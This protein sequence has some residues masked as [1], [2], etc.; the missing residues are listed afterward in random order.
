MTSSPLPAVGNTDLPF[1]I[2]G[3]GAFQIQQQRRKLIANLK[4]QMR[5]S[6]CQ[7]F[8]HWTGDSQ[9]PNSLSRP[10]KGSCAAYFTVIEELDTDVIG[11]AFVACRRPTTSSMVCP[12]EHVQPAAIQRGANGTQKHMKC[13]EC[14]MFLLQDGAA[15]KASGYIVLGAQRSAHAA[16]MYAERSG[17]PPHLTDVPLAEEL[18]A[19]DGVQVPEGVELDFVMNPENMTP[20]MQISQHL[21]LMISNLGQRTSCSGLACFPSR[22]TTLATTGRLC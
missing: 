2:Q 11:Q 22:W 3:S 14:D 17:R 19:S 10:G 7:Y 16:L 5:C 4:P 12:C 13:L 20:T 9:C 21:G 8:G 6:V 1:K 18:P 15:V